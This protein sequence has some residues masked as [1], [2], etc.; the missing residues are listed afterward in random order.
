MKVIVGCEFSQIVTKAFREKGHDAYSC[1]IIPCEGG[2]TEWHYQCDVLELLKKEKFDLGIFHPPCTYLS[3]A[4]A[5]Y[6]NELG[7]KEKREKALK[8][9]MDL[10]NAEILKICIENPHG[11][12]RIAFRQPDQ[13]IHPYY[14]GDREMKRICLWLKNLPKLLHFPQDD[15]LGNKKTHTEKPK[16]NFIRKDG[17]KQYFCSVNR[18]QK[19]RSKFW[20]GI[21]EAMANQWG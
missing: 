9:F 13:E 15:L 2:H 4:G 12:P 14:F 6:W 1:D 7:R 21:A 8:F 18:D 17:N 10:Y 3:Y 16:P 5:A 11:Y 19:V 20:P